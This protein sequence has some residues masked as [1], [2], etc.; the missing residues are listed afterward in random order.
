MTVA[1]RRPM[2]LRHDCELEVLQLPARFFEE[3]D[4]KLGDEV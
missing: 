2:A 1:E 4:K 3:S